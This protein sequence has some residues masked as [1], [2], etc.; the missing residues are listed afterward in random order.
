MASRHNL[1]RKLGDLGV[2]ISSRK[3]TENFCLIGT[4]LP[5]LEKAKDEF[6]P[7]WKQ[8]VRDDKGRRRLHG[9]FTGGFSAGYFNTV[10]SAEGWTPSTFV[11]SRNERAK[12]KTA[13]PEDFMD[14][15]D[16]EAL[17]ESR[18]LVNTNEQVDLKGDNR[19][20][21]AG[22]DND[23]IAATLQSA[24]QPLG[25]DSAGAR[26]L[27]KMGWRFGQGIGPRITLKERKQQDEEAFDP[28]TGLKHPG[29][30]L[31]VAVDD[32]EA[33]K[34]TYP[35]RDVPVLHVPRKTNRHGL[36]YKSSI[37]LND[38][39]GRGTGEGSKSGLQ[40]SAGFGLGALNDADEDDLDVY[41][42]SSASRSKVAFDH[43]DDNE[44]S[45]VIGGRADRS[46]NPRTT[47]TKQAQFFPDGTPVVP[48]FTPSEDPVM[49]DKWF[50]GPEVPAG[51]KP[52]PQRVWD[53][54]ANKE[55]LKKQLEAAPKDR[56]GRPQLSAVDRGDI[57]GEAPLTAGPRSVFDFI[58]AKDKE[59]IQRIA[60]GG[61]PTSAPGPPPAPSSAVGPT[62]APP[63]TKVDPQAA[64]AAL[65]GF[66]PYTSD[67]AKQARYIAFLHSQATPDAAPPLK[68]L[69]GQDLEQFVKELA[70]YTKSAQVFK[71]LSGAMAGRF[72][73]AAVVE[74]APKIFEGLHQPTEEE[75]AEK[76]EERKRDEEA[77]V[78]P[79]MHAAKMGIYGPMTRESSTWVPVALLCKRFGVKQPEPLAEEDTGAGKTTFESTSFEQEASAAAASNLYGTAGAS[80]GAGASSS[81]SAMASDL[82]RKLENVGL[83]DDETQG[84]DILTYERPPMDIFK[85]IFASDD[86]D[87]DDEPEQEDEEV[88]EQDQK[89]AAP[90]V[91]PMIEVSGPVD[92]ATFKPTFIPRAKGKEK[93]RGDEKSRDKRDKKEKR[94]KKA[95]TLSFAAEEDEG[96]PNFG[97]PA[98]EKER[99]K[100]KRKEERKEKAKATHN[101]MDMVVDQPI[102]TASAGDVSKPQPSEHSENITSVPKG[103]KRAVDFLEE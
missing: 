45:M 23:P 79:K 82:P 60:T 78:T 83:G 72:T 92:L 68:Q 11:S 91:K 47:A 100:K 17:R 32:E 42:S 24:F 31:S 33:S 81:T 51:W 64:Q 89:A 53:A 19:L 41:D 49:D 57:L 18:Q 30:S 12:Q 58:S 29:Q 4:P 63:T 59:R 93:D 43:M 102:F 16:L 97:I 36:D 40:I 38:S 8:E 39:L 99:P 88:P 70:D 85:A 65:H 67:P 87:S 80:S 46:A 95:A 26:I 69:P 84:A 10:G 21:I 13:R 94:K 54:G 90:D 5:S 96:E 22:E 55:N 1:K 2:D 75:M 66:Q 86:E 3:A 27:K 74:N 7:L 35:R 9:A 101:E 48:G 44:E 25:N 103:R 6:V 37:S 34:H 62:P 20:P 14:E 77:K 28:Y 15:E 50:P 61:L 56:A 73:S 76:E 98:K 71:P 52:N